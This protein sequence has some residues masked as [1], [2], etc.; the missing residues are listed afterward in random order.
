MWLTMAAAYRLLIDNR[1]FILFLPLKKE[2]T[3]LGLPIV[4]KIVEAHDGSLHILDSPSGGTIFRIKLRE[5]PQ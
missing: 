2:G 1:F 3:G 4:K 5:L